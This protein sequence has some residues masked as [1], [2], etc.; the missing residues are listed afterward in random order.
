MTNSKPLRAWRG[1]LGAALL[2]VAALAAPP[3]AADPAA[4]DVDQNI[5]KLKEQSL[6]LVQQ[7]QAVE[8][9]FLYPDY[10]RLSVYIGVKISGMVLNDINVSIDGGTP[11]TYQY[12]REEAVQLQLQ[13][14]RLHRLVV[15]NAPP[16][17]HRIHA[18]FTAQ[19]GDAKPTDPPFTG[20]FDGSF[21]K[22]EQ[23]PAD[24]ELE[25]RRDGYLTRPELKMHD[26]RAAQ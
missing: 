4:L 11:T 17:R 19:Y 12:P 22:T 6:D 16:G 13:N 8:Q 26:W 14:T 15:M 18:T 25:L 21:D 1:L 23:Q 2:P 10:N 24:I 7:A 9:A 20:S 3:Q 5:Q